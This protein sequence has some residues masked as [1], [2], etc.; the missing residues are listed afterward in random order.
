MRNAPNVLFL[1]YAD[2]VKD[3][4]GTVSKLA[5]FVGVQLTDSEHAKIVEK[6]GMTLFVV[7]ARTNKR[8]HH[9]HIKS[10]PHKFRYTMPL[11]PKFNVK[12]LSMVVENVITAPR[13]VDQL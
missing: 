1:H 12:N 4:K 13:P 5:A 10:V 9:H 3:L 2:A 11:K 8:H 6:C 7:S